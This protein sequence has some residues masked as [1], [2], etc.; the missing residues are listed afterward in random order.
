MPLS[1][2]DQ[3]YLRVA[4]GYFELGMFEDAAAELQKITP[5]ACGQPETL[6]LRLAIA[7]ET[8]RW[9][10]MQAA[11][12]KLAELDPTAP[13]WAI[14]SAYATRRAES[15]ELARLILIDALDRHPQEALIHYN[16]ACY[17][18]VL[19]NMESAKEFLTRALKLDPTMKQ[20]ALTDQDLE[21]LRP[22]L[23]SHAR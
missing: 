21:P 9:A 18:C 12:R 11:A 23:F 16:L 10:A 5:E 3:T 7:Q 17:D 20:M 6:I 2:D 14:A 19:N 22:W 8:K 1:P 13:Q 15:I 4:E